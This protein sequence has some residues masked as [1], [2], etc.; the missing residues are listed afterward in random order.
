MCDG[1]MSSIAFSCPNCQTNLEAQPEHAGME[2]SCPTCQTVMVVPQAAPA[3]AESGPKGKYSKAPSTVQHSV[4]S[5]TAASKIARKGKKPPYGLY[6]GLGLGAAA[7]VAGIHFGPDLYAK[8]QQHH[9]QA[10]AAAI[11][12]TNPPPPP[13]PPDLAANEIMEHVTARYKSFPSYSM[14]GESTATID[15]SAVN[16]M[17]KNPI[18]L[19]GKVS[20]LLGRPSGYRIEWERDVAGKV[21]KGSAWSAGRGDFIQ[22][23]VQ[24]IRMKSREANLAAAAMASGIPGIELA[25]S[26]F[27]QTNSLAAALKGLAK[28]NNETLNGHKCYVLTG[29]AGFQKMLFWIHKDDFLIVQAEI[30]FGGKIQDSDL[31]GLSAAQK[32]VV[33][34]MGKWKGNVTETYSD[35]ETNRDVKA[36]DF[37][38]AL[39]M[40]AR[41]Q[42]TGRMNDPAM[43]RRMAHGVRT[44]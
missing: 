16:P 39:V 13:P 30:I 3:A 2:V 12:A 38:A 1:T 9:D 15:E 4:T 5:A 32:I 6:I 14:H 23:S 21:L 29:Q 42:Q 17:L 25:T 8:Y 40:T 34:Q 22:T 33:Q 18:Q 20:M 41:P 36:S 28:T 10:V 7:V 11:A 24:P 44:Q 27:D 35:I 43:D 31:A 26:F 37:Q 19:T